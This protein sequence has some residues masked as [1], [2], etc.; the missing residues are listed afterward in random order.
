MWRV[1][2]TAFGNVLAV[3]LL[4]GAGLVF[5][6]PFSGPWSRV[7]LAL[8]DPAVAQPCIG[9]DSILRGS[10]VIPLLAWSGPLSE[11]MVEQK[12]ER[13][14]ATA[15][16]RYS[17]QWS[18]SRCLSFVLRS[19][20]VRIEARIDT[21][22]GRYFGEVQPTESHVRLDGNELCFDLAVDRDDGLRSQERWQGKIPIR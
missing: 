14:R 16:V 21:N 20:R 5:L 1:L 2:S 17:S 18:E 10:R 4:A 13:D 12:I 19:G 8:E 7:D 6:S 15:F 3:V 22:N 9:G 11:P